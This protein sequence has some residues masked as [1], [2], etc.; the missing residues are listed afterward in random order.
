MKMNIGTATRIGFFKMATSLTRSPAD[1]TA[2]SGTRA[3]AQ[4]RLRGP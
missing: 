2:S 4:V 3:A 1:T